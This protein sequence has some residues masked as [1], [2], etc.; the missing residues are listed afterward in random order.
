M[1]WTLKLHALLL[2]VVV[3]QSKVSHAIVWPTL[4]KTNDLDLVLVPPLAIIKLLRS[5]LLHCMDMLQR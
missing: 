4:D 2:L 5:K 3:L 1:D